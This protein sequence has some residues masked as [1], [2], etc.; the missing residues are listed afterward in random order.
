MNAYVY[1]AGA[2]IAGDK[3]RARILTIHR[4]AI[5][6]AGPPLIPGPV[7]SQVWRGDPRS[8]H[9]ARLISDCE[10]ILSYSVD[11]YKEAGRIL[12][13]ACLPGR[14]KPDTIDALV[15]ITAATRGAKAIV[16][17]DGDDIKACLD[18]LR[19]DCTVVKV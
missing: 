17:S 9:M 5:Q 11:E 10:P 16:T 2:L 12:S 7:I 6:T 4:R 15:A 1:D 3:A 8:V 18:V 14:K 13:E 19:Y